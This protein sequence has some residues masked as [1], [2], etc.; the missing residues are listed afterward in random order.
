MVFG[1][2]KQIEVSLDKLTY[3]SGETITG[4]VVL[5]LKRPTDAKQLRVELIGVGERGRG[6]HRMGGMVYWSKIPLDGEKTYAGGEYRFQIPIPADLFESPTMP[7][8][9]I[10]KAVGGLEALTGLSYTIGM[11]N[12]FWHVRAV[13]ERPRKLDICTKWNFTSKNPDL[14]IRQPT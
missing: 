9:K 4:K 3:S 11:F 1:L 14:V 10:G 6:R 2:G 7:G 12:T 8:T 13:L 5:K